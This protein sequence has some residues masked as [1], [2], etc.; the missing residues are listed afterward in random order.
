MKEDKAYIQHIYEAVCDIERFIENTNFESFLKNKEKQYAV[1]RAIEIIGEASK[2]ISKELKAKYGKI[3]W[4]KIAGIRDILL[5][6]VILC[7]MP[8]GLM[9]FWLVQNLSCFKKD[10]RQAGMTSKSGH[11]YAGV[12]NS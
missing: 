11:F 9:S 5:K 6:P 8:R 2:N 10:S 4:K 12:N 1:I 7:P 3:P